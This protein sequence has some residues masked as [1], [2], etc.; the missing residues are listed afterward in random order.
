M[1]I[2]GISALDKESTATLVENGKIIAAISEERITRVKQQ[3]WFPFR[4]VEKIFAQYNLKTGDIDR[5]AFAFL[6][7]DQEWH[8]RR[9]RY[10]ESVRFALKHFSWGSILHVLNF[11][12]IMMRSTIHTKIHLS[13]IKGLEYYGLL[14]KLVYVHHHQAHAAA[15]Y[16]TSGIK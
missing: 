4:S 7:V 5:V 13:L 8:L 14:D 2:L 6:P 11:S 3:S 10:W 12:R 15:A 16:F 1:K 9:Q